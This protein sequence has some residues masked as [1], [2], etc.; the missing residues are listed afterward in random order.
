[1]RIFLSLEKVWLE[2]E[3]QIL[4]HVFVIALNYLFD[5]EDLT[6]KNSDR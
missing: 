3:V 5:L 4:N 2:F 6:F 1:M